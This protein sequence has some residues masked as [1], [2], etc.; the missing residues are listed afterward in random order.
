MDDFKVDFED[1][2]TVDFQVD[3]KVDLII[4]TVNSVDGFKVNLTI[5]FLV[6]LVDDFRVDIT[7]D[8]L[9]KFRQSAL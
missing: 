7:V 5:N 9:R 6:D 1:I 8:Y 4:M 2:L 3:F